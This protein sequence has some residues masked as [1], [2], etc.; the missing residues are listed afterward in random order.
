VLAGMIASLWGQGMNPQDAAWCGA[1]LHGLAGDVAER[2]MG[3]RS[4]VAGDIIEALPESFRLIETG[5]TV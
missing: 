1:F 5:G 2:R 3:Q 4:L